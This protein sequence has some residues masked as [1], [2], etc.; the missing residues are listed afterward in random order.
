MH[1]PVDEHGIPVSA[2]VPPVVYI[3]AFVGV[4]VIFA[5]IGMVFLNSGYGHAWPSS[6][7][8]TVPLS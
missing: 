5:M 7:S 1:D 6:T 8:L 3:V 4:I 2:G